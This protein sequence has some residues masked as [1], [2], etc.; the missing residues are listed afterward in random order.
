MNTVDNWPWLC[1]D[2]C[3]H[4]TLQKLPTEENSFSVVPMWNSTVIITIYLI[5]WCVSDIFSSSCENENIS[6]KYDNFRLFENI[7]NLVFKLHQHIS[8]VCFYHNVAWIYDLRLLQVTSA[9]L[10]CF[11][12]KFTTCTSTWNSEY[13]IQGFLI[14]VLCAW[15][16]S[17]FSHIH[18]SVWLLIQ[19]T[20]CFSHIPIQSYTWLRYVHA[21]V[22]PKFS[23]DEAV[24]H[25]PKNSDM[26]D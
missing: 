5:L 14:V 23:S 4:W 13:M 8:H 11:Y 20:T 24:W 12:H 19:S 6:V 21:S 15:V 7:T 16:L 1:L 9:Y 2:L 26:V 22:V 10:A 3:F 25:S 17:R 18:A